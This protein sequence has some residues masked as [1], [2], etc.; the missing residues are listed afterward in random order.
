M[1][2]NSNISIEELE[3]KIKNFLIL[4]N[5]LDKQILDDNINLFL[6]Y[7]CHIWQ[8]YDHNFSLKE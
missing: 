6:N 3:K 7:L 2:N 8:I 4:I 5:L 1:E